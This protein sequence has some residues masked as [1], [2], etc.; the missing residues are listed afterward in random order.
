MFKVHNLVYPCRRQFF[1]LRNE[2]YVFDIV[3]KINKRCWYILKVCQTLLILIKDKWTS[4]KIYTHDHHLKFVYQ[5]H[6]SLVLGPNIVVDVEWAQQV[7]KMGKIRCHCIYQ[8]KVTVS[9]FH[10]EKSIMSK[11]HTHQLLISTFL[12]LA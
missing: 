7:Y 4:N 11:N 3:N 6:M 8:M 10:L 9:H 5:I 1:L 2:P 12:D